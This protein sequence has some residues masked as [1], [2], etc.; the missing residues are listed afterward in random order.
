VLRASDGNSEDK[1]DEQV[2]TSSTSPQPV[3]ASEA[4]QE[5]EAGGGPKFLGI[6]LNDPIN[7]TLLIVI[8]ISAT[9]DLWFPIFF[10]KVN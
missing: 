5:G 4:K 2:A 1:R 9:R 8:A 3:T 7:A 10:D 6:Y